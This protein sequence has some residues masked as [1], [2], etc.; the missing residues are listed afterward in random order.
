MTAAA[1]SDKGLVDIHVRQP[2][3]LTPGAA[4]EWIRQELGRK[5]AEELAA[6]GVVPPD[7]FIWHAVTR[8][9][10]NVKN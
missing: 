7:K 4:R 8:A 1:T 2:L 6:D 10:G 5:E 3:V 9:V